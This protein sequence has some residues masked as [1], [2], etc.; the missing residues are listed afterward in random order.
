MDKIIERLNKELE[1]I[2]NQIDEKGFTKE[3]L[4]ITGKLLEVLKDAKEVEMM[5]EE[6][7]ENKE[8]HFDSHQDKIST[9]NKKY[10][11]N[12]HLRDYV[13]RIDKGIDIYE[14]GKD[15]YHHGDDDYRMIEG[16]EKV[17]YG[18]CMFIECMLDFAESPQEKEVIRHH[19]RKLKNM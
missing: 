1:L 10:P 4:E 5:C 14:E 17:M 15:K 13:D 8:H 16:L 3:K 2:E 12:T 18:I 7:E 19:I 6:H 11:N 9:Y